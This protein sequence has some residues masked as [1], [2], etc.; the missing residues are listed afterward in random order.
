MRSFVLAALVAVSMS[1]GWAADVAEPSGAALT[2]VGQFSDDHLSGMLSRAGARQPALI[3]ASQ[4]N[5]QLVAAVFDAEID[6]AVAQYG[7][8][9]QR[10]MAQSWMG[11]L[12]DEQ[13]TSL[14]ADGAESPHADA[15]VGLRNEAGGNMQ[16]NAGELFQKILAE[17][18]D[19]TITELGTA[20]PA[21]DQ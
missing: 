6:R 4:L 18:M 12:N 13:F 16:K 8:D 10:A 7:P 20:A 2:F 3:A 9:W 17:V 19:R 11:L 14:V 1:P 5:G 21:A 15:Y